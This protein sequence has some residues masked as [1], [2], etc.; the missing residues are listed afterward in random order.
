MPTDKKLIFAVI[1][2]VALGG[3]VALQ[4]KSQ[5]A[6]AAAHS[7]EGETASL[8]KLKI[9]EDDI[10]KIDKVDMTRGGDSDTSPRENIVL[11]KKGDEDWDLEKPTAAKASASTVKSMLDDLKRLEVKE[12]ID[13]SKDSYAKYKVSDDKALHAVF[14][15]GKDV[16]LDAY[17]GED[18]SRGQMTRIAGH[19][20]VYAVKGYSSY[21][22]NKDAK[23][24]RD[25]T[26]L[27]FEENDV[28]KVSLEDA[29]G[30]FTFD[31]TGDDWKAKFAKPKG[32]PADLDKFD[33]SKLESLIRAYKAL[34]AADFGDGKTAAD[35]GLDK[36]LATLTFG[37][38]DGGKTAVTFGGTAESNRW[39]QKSG[40]EQIW[41]VSSWA[42]DWATANV[43]KFQKTEE[44]KDA[45]KDKK[46]DKKKPPSSIT[47]KE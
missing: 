23:S 34:S 47:V 25:K 20:A 31:K 14:Y 40:S 41:S 21:T 37:M 10:K 9:T 19:D 1:V 33:K 11:V 17:F 44:K 39:I 27:K 28:V 35:T 30:S 12:L 29:N 24:W 43:D 26:I 7:V 6:D 8:P 3:A 42:G 15:K 22:F 38:K 4:Q 16:V 36:P 2:L 13:S 5:T 18:G 45:D 46:D 32:T